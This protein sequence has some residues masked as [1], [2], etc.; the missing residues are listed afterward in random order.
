MADIVVEKTPEQI[1]QEQSLQAK[2]KMVETIVSVYSKQQSRRARC[3]DPVTQ[4]ILFLDR[5][6]LIPDIISA[7]IESLMVGIPDEL[8][9]KVQDMNNDISNNIGNLI[10]WIQ[11]PQYAPDHPIGNKLMQESKDHF[12]EH[13]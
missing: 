6:C 12:N 9:D 1:A 7:G 5:L 10:E 3:V 8:K 11:M 13:K 4:H 2:V